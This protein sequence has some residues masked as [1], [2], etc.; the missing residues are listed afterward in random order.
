MTVVRTDGGHVQTKQRAIMAEQPN[1]H[2]DHDGPATLRFNRS[3][4]LSV[5]LDA[6]V[7][8]A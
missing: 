1:I 2:Y 8:K 3:A 5:R 7:K 4:G 6:L